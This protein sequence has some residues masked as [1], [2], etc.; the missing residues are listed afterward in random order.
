MADKV[1]ICNLALARIGDSASVSD[2][3]EQTPQANACK[4]FYPLALSS[5]LDMHNWSFA[6]RRSLVAE[7]VD[8]AV[9]KGSWYHA[10]SLPAGCKRV[11]D[12]HGSEELDEQAKARQSEIPPSLMTHKHEFEVVGT[13]TGLVL[14]TNVLNPVVRY[15]VEEPK[16]SQFPGLFI[17]A[18][19]W[20]MASYLAGEIVR[21]DS[22]FSYAQNCQRKFQETMVLAMQQDAKQEY[23]KRKFVPAWIARR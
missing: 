21:G 2:L 6:T 19:A 11:I 23:V 20:L 12:I 13:S 17:D 22:A 9:S 8:G 15:I 3:S 5:C 18:L 16:E 1:T 4:R 7:L 14:L 10:Y